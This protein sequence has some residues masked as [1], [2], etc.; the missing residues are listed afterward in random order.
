MERTCPGTQ[1][2]ADG[3][4]NTIAPGLLPE[5]INRLTGKSVM[6]VTDVMDMEMAVDITR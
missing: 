6:R 5:A 4:A 3:K 2:H 1:A